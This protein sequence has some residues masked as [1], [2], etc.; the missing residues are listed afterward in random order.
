[1]RRFLFMLSL[2]PFTTLLFFSK[3]LRG[4]SVTVD[5]TPTSAVNHFVPD[6]TLGAGVDRLSKE[7]IDKAFTKQNLDRI[8]PSGWQPITYRQN[9][10]LA[11]EAWHWNPE[12][13]W[14][15]ARGRGYFT[16][17]TKLAAPIRYS[18]GY[19]LP[20]RGFT[21]NDGTGN[22]GYS[23]LT[24][25]DPHS[26]WKSNPYLAQ[27]FTG[28]DDSAHAQWVIVDL[29]K[30]EPINSI[31]I[32]WAA[33]YA[34]SYLIQAWTGDDPIG[35]PTRGA[36]ETLP[37]GIISHG[38][39]GVQ[40]ISLAEEPVNVRF[41]RILMTKSSNTCDADGSGDIRNCVGYAINELYIGTTTPD[42]AFHDVLRHTPRPGADRDVV[43]F[44]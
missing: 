19:A 32:A 2:L 20:R 22:T 5:M 15:D 10:D 26:F 23:R 9:T 33:P 6:A 38:N 25:G 13:T 42:G 11:V 18:Y 21:R 14:S 35:S 40:T 43:L 1:M 31:R 4:Q 16:G 8:A 3:P 30:H 29:I 41:L 12:G 24:D 34:T 28:E 39:G 44:R 37:N 27:H 17:S 7:A 36:W